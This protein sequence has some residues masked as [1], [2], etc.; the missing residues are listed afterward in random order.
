M[1][2]FTLFTYCAV[3]SA[4]AI[5]SGKAASELNDN[6]VHYGHTTTGF[7]SGTDFNTDPTWTSGTTGFWHGK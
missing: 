1:N 2:F 7:N 6:H 3:I 4:A 5:E